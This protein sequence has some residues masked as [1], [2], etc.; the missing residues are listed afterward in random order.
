M[1]R[2]ITEED[3][4]DKVICCCFSPRDASLYEEPARE[5]FSD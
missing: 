4:I 2:F 3:G 5:V 1:K